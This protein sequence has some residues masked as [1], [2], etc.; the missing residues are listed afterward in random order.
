[1]LDGMNLAKDTYETTMIILGVLSAVL[2]FGVACK[3]KIS[4]W[5]TTRKVANERV[6]QNMTKDIE[7]KEDIE[8][9]SQASTKKDEIKKTKRILFIDDNPYPITKLMMKNG[10]HHV[11]IVSEIDSFESSCIKDADVIL[12]DIIGVGKNLG[13]TD[14]GFGLSKALKETYPKKKIVIYSQEPNEFHD[15][16]KKV[17]LTIKKTSN[18]YELEQEILS[19]FGAKCE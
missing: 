10:W 3:A 17:D 8:L 9:N 12:V 15:A 6:E 5:W 16:I 7:K 14:Q 13:F 1:M 4:A 18:I 11:N 2:V 19:L